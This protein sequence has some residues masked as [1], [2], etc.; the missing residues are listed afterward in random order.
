MRFCGPSVRRSVP[1]WEPEWGNEMVL[2]LFV[3]V[4]PHAALILPLN[5]WRSWRAWE[6]VW[7]CSVIP[8]F[9]MAVWW[10]AVLSDQSSRI[11]TPKG[12]TITGPITCIRQWGRPGSHIESWYHEAEAIFRHHCR[13]DPHFV[14]FG[15]Q[16]ILF[17]Y[18][19]VTLDNRIIGKGSQS[20]G[21]V[22]WVFYV[23]WAGE[24]MVLTMWLL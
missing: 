9:W 19:M 10:Y 20:L 11:T 8:N 3:F 13:G 12:H 17:G 4:Q 24:S 15:I 1:F 7:Q 22:W 18:P 21:F 23:N 14:L 2:R 5:A 16:D 6:A